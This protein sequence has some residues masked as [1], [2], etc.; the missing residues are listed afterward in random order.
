MRL[1]QTQAEGR[2][3]HHVQTVAVGGGRGRGLGRLA[4]GRS[5]LQLYYLQYFTFCHVSCGVPWNIGLVKLFV[6]LPEWGSHTEVGAH[7]D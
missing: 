5:V 1:P 6:T 2:H 4:P 7:G 3:T